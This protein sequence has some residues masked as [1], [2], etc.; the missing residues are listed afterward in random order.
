M[1]KTDLQEDGFNPNVVKDKL[2]YV[3]PKT[4][5]YVPLDLAAYDKINS[6]DIRL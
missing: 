4:G 1:K 3:D 2:F 5:K 6:G